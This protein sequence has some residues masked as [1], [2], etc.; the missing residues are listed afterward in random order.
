[1]DGAGNAYVTG[2]TG[3]E[4]F[5]TK[6]NPTGTALVYS[7]Y[8]GG[9]ETDVNPSIAVDSAGNAYVTGGTTSTNFPVT[10]GAFQM[11]LRCVYGNAFVTEL[12]PTGSTLV[13]STYLG[14]SGSVTGLSDEGS[15]IAVDNAG[16]AYVTGSTSS[17][18]FPV[19]PGAF[20]T[21]YGG[22]CASGGNCNKNA[23]VTELN[24]TGSA[25][26]YSTYLGG[27]A[28]D[29]G[30]GIAVDSAGNAYVTG[31]AGSP[32]FPVTPGAFQTTGG[33]AFVTK[34][35]PTGSAL[36][37]ST[38][39]N[40][41][42][43]IGVAVD[44]A[45]HAYVAGSAVG[46]F[47]VTSGAFQ[48]VYG[49][50]CSSGSTCT[51]NAFV[52]ELNPT[53]SA[54]VYSTYLGGKG[55]DWGYG[56]D[57]DSAGDAYVTGETFSTNF[58]VTPG[59]LQTQCVYHNIWCNRLHGDMFV[60][61]LN[62]AGSALA[63]STYLGGN[64]VGYGIAVDSSDSAY[65][66][67]APYSASLPS[68][69]PITPGAFETK[70]SNGFGCVFVTKMDLRV[71]TTIKLTSSQNPST[72]GQSVTFTA[73][74][75]VASGAY[76]PPDGETVTFELGKTALGTGTLFGGSASFMTSTLKGGTNS[77]TAVYGGDSNFLGSTSKAVKQV[78]DKATTSIKLTSSANPS[79]VGKS[80]TFTAT[81]T[82]EFS[83]TV[84]GKVVFYDGTTLLKSVAVSG[85][86][87]EFTTSKL[88]TG[89]HSIT[90]TYGG[91]ADFTGSTSAA[92]IQ[93]VN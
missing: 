30:Y 46:G 50:T 80:V 79:S 21:V 85:G 13:Y 59:A 40:N 82:P 9:S 76:T 22:I 89:P 83:G 47:P 72:Y 64:T 23:F 42:T 65:V 32:N 57:I 61:K 73:Q 29:V 49:G 5:V 26:V 8:L 31:G 16:N 54:L 68:R 14:G 75:L 33:G 52:T 35:N 88:A 39:L 18:D 63:Y 45:G 15:A 66:V 6:F 81:V 70:C 12:N 34:F 37:Y 93:T 2:V 86:A 91:S 10:P 55:G 78:V 44:S 84:T 69:I 27:S 24:P 25:L 58:P 62:T 51:S 28:W 20:Q 92:V 19:T 1:M 87:A 90:A 60:A 48:T 74:A 67:G 36:V 4:I 11:T 71:L 77:V 53:G 7:T 38:Y 43:G 17:T 56:I 3:G 41:G